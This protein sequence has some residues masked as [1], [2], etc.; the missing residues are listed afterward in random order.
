MERR[1]RGLITSVVAAVG[2]AA[3]AVGPVA[4]PDVD[5]RRYG[6]LV[7]ALRRARPKRPT[8][9]GRVVGHTPNAARAVR[10]HW[11]RAY[12]NAMGARMSTRTWRRLKKALQRQHIRRTGQLAARFLAKVLQTRG[13]A[14]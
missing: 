9:G 12:R 5:G 2:M 14:R 1:Q 7:Q 11:E 10:R 4:P 13:G 3:A 6:A 8:E